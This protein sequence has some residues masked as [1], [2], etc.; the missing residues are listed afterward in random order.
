M[1]IKRLVSCR[2]AGKVYSLLRIPASQGEGACSAR[3]LVGERELPA[4]LFALEYR[5]VRELGLDTSFTY[6]VLVTPFLNGRV[7]RVEITRLT[8]LSTRS[9]YGLMR[10][11]WRPFLRIEPSWRSAPLFVT[12][13]VIIVLI[14]TALRLTTVFRV[15]RTMSGVSGLIGR[16][17]QTPSRACRVWR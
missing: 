4:S 9:P 3:L 17:M 10:L 14:G 8:L 12:L 6:K 13:I 15:L 2:S 16:A 5:K 1:G 11:K 7:A